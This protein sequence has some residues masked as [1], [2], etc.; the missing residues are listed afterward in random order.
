MSAK[1]KRHAALADQMAQARGI[2]LQDAA[3]ANGMTPDEVAEMVLTCTKCLRTRDCVRWLNA[4]NGAVSETP[5]YC[6][7]AAVFAKL[8]SG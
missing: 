4:V 5:V 8:A 7:N 3:I 6:R 1:L 2:D